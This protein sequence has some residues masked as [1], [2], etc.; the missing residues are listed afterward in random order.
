MSVNTGPPLKGSSEGAGGT[1]WAR[2]TAWVRRRL[3]RPAVIG[4]IIAGPLLFGLWLGTL[5][6]GTAEGLAFAAQMVG[7]LAW[8][9]VLAII[10]VLLRHGIDRITI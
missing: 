6:S 3:L 9:V 2:L 7:S 1:I 5:L 8:P 4:L 10:V